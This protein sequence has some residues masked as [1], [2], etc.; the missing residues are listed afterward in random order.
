MISTASDCGCGRAGTATRDGGCGC[1][2]RGVRDVTGACG[3]G[4]PERCAAPCLERPAFSAGQLLTADALRLGQRYLEDRLALRRYVDGVGVVCGMHVRC[5]PADP[6]WIVV[7]PGYAVGCCGEDL[8]LCDPVRMDLCAALK[9]CPRPP[10]PCGPVDERA[11]SAA[12]P[13][14][15]GPAK[16]T[17]E[18]IRDYDRGAVRGTVTN[19]DGVPLASA[20]VAVEGTN[21]S[22]TTD[23]EGRFWFNTL[24]PGGYT[25][26][27]RRTGAQPGRREVVAAPG[28][29]TV[30]DFVLPVE[31][32]IP[33]EDPRGRESTY[34][35]RAEVAWEEREPVPVVTARGSGDPRTEC[36]PSREAAGVRLRLEPLGADDAVR[37][38]DERVARFRAAGDALFD[39]L[40]RAFAAQ[41]E[42]EARFARAALD[43]LL[44]EVQERPPRSLGSLA[45]VLCELRRRMDGRPP[46]C[47]LPEWMREKP[48]A[49][50]AA[51]AVRVV[52]DLRR[53]ALSAAC[54]GCCERA[55]VRLA[56]LTVD[57]RLAACGEGGC[58]I[59]RIDD[60]PPARE[61]L[62]PR[63]DAW[64]ADRVPLY[65]AYFRGA[66][67][68]GVL[69]S[70]RGLRVSEREVSG[71]GYAPR[72]PKLAGEWL[73]THATDEWR[74]IGVYQ[75]NDL[76]A[77]YGAAVVLWTAEGRVVA[78]DVEEYR[79]LEGEIFQFPTTQRA[80]EEGAEGGE[81][82][83][84]PGTRG[85]LDPAL[86]DPAPFFRAID[87]VG[88]KMESHLFRA[89]IRTFLELVR[90]DYDAVRK[91][92]GSR[93]PLTREALDS[94]QR[95][96]ADILRGE[97]PYPPDQ[98]RAWSEEAAKR[99]G[100]PP[101]EGR[102]A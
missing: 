34:V 76:Y 63:D 101:Q 67:E 92:L 21:W 56:H 68:A 10:E 96:A 32:P 19:A 62:H 70:G 50:L 59:V 79:R 80:V 54:A 95:Q 81:G 43:V 18:T 22:A 94:M 90:A 57:P 40:D 75:N 49:F 6:G 89:G 27:A 39:R 33:V 77:R 7:E 12:E 23:A 86:L 20:Q 85:E 99:A 69:L 64:R 52:E 24:S 74:R 48:G 61:P 88:E 3:S 47:T 26:V 65:D 83:L 98:L 72:L 84:E 25:L 66:A 41:G 4:W 71:Y 87:G 97:H 17:E 93:V 102:Q 15:L 100:L 55:G 45:D 16:P 28:R 35:L 8:V 78:V 29:V 91:V 14:D 9:S 30:A 58:G 51:T 46:R 2:S 11:P 42:G 60:H 44:R 37:R 53:E 1:G 5:D 31:A 82:W 73:R 13:V 36:R 38:A